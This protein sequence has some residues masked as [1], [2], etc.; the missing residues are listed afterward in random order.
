MF[1]H[2]YN[3]KTACKNA[4]LPNDQFPKFPNLPMVILS[5][6]SNILFW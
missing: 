5:L 4:N 6:T 1:P 2:Q 3:G